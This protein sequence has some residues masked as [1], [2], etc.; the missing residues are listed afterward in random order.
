MV[1]VLGRKFIPAQDSSAE[2]TRA[3]S[4]GTSTNTDLGSVLSTGDHWTHN[5]RAVVSLCDSMG[6]APGADTK[7]PLV[8]RLGWDPRQHWE[9]QRGRGLLCPMASSEMLLPLWQPL[10]H[11]HCSPSETQCVAWG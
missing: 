11:A 8:A 4:V 7:S 9:W 10:A 5:I 3:L 6:V 2:V 1:K